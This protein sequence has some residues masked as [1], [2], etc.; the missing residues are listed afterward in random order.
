MEGKLAG[1][2]ISTCLEPSGGNAGFEP[3]F[4]KKNPTTTWMES[5]QVK[6]DLNGAVTGIMATT[7]AGQGHESLVATIIGEV[8]Q[9][10]P[11][12]IRVVRTDSLASLPSNS[13]VGSRMAIMLGGAAQGAAE[14]IKDQ[15]ILIASH[16]L[17]L[18]TNQLKYHNGDVAAIDDPNIKIEWGELVEIAHRRFHDMPD[19]TEPGL[20]ARH[21]WEVPTGGSM[22]TAEGKVQMYPCYSFEA[23][24]PLV[25]IDP[26]TGQVTIHNYYIGHDCGTQINPNI[27]HGMTYG[28][29]A[30]GIGAALYEKFE[31]NE[32]GQLLAG[33]FMDYLLPSAHEIPRIEMVDHCTASPL[34]PMG[35]KGSGEGGYLGAPAAL[36]SA[37]NDALEPLGGEILSLPMRVRDIEEVLCDLI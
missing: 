30:H 8:L 24:I 19:G 6:I 12:T 20:Q 5:C 3:L 16:N 37:V 23:H 31:Y 25:S 15:L 29:I 27:V 14:K 1:V 36:A 7:S 33:T 17:Q 4:N 9:R 11:E 13:P 28:G 21:V 10:D 18:A 26:L 22:P 35:Q 32:D 2:G 34:T